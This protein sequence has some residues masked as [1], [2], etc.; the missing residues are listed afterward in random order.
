VAGRA[1]NLIVVLDASTFV[2]AALKT[3]SVPERARLRAVNEPN[4]LLLSQEEVEHEYREVTAR[5]GILSTLA[6]VQHEKT[7]AFIKSPIAQ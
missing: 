5:K 3:D 1:K 7:Q 2:S 4:R 6:A